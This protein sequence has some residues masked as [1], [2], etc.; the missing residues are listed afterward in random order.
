MQVLART[1]ARRLDATLAFRLVPVLCGVLKVI[2]D[3]AL[4]AMFRTVRTLEET[5]GG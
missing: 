5:P 1:D 4:L 2:Y 3:V